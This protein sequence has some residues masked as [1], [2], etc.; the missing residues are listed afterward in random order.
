MV[1]RAMTH[2]KWG[3]D[4]PQTQPLI[5]YIRPKCGGALTACEQMHFSFFSFTK[6]KMSAIPLGHHINAPYIDPIGLQ[7]H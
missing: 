5:K 7:I 2:G 1:I 6:K 3:W 4:F